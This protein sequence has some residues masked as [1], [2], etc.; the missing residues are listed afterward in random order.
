MQMPG[1]S[2][3]EQSETEKSYALQRQ[4]S[5]N[6]SF[7]A[8]AAPR[9][10]PGQFAEIRQFS[11]IPMASSMKSRPGAGYKGPARGLGTGKTKIFN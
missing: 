9:Q 8:F 2:N 3:V 6:N 10:I 5:S 7:E 1:R 11:Q 4:E